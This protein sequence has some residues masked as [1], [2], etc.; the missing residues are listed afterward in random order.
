[1]LDDTPNLMRLRELE[2]VEKIAE[3]GQL[4]ISLDERGLRERLTNLV[5]GSG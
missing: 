1:M 5:S 3:S 4:S 2:L